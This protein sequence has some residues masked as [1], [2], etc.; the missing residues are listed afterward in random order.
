MCGGAVMMS[1]DPTGG[2]TVEAKVEE[3]S[4]N[5]VCDE[6]GAEGQHDHTC[7]ACMRCCISAAASACRSA[8]LSHSRAHASAA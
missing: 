2:G 6:E 5:G 7:A 3:W 1:E 4:R 8:S